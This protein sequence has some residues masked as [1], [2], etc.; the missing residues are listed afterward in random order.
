[1][2]TCPHC[3]GQIRPSVIRCVHCGTALA[4][5]GAGALTDTAPAADKTGPAD[6]AVEAAATS[7]GTVAAVPGELGARTVGTSAVPGPVSDPWVTPA[8]RA[9]AQT[10]FSPAVPTRRAEIAR[11]TRRRTDGALVLAAVLAVA[12]AIAAYSALP[13]P[14]VRAELTTTGDGSD[15]TVV[16]DMTFRGSDSVAG[17]LGLGVAVALLALGLLWFWYALDRGMNLPTFAHPLL[18]LLGAALGA[19]VLAFSRLGYLFWDEAFVARA[20]EA[21][22]AKEAMRELL[23]ARPAPTIAVE[24]LSGVYRFGA[25]VLLA[26]AAGVVAWWS[27]RR[28]G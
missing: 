22:M 16:A 14:W 28:R 6:G 21:G 23:D 17:T 19:V 1:M 27:Q 15:V 24:Q 20:R 2:R 9:D 11:T 13:L 26:L 5:Q 12:G 10:R 4:G 18:A 25:A 3:G 8:V 7:T